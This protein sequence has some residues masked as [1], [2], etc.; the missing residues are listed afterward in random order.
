LCFF[1]PR[2]TLRLAGQEH[3]RGIPLAD[4]RTAAKSTTIRSHH[5]V[6][7]LPSKEEAPARSRGKGQ[8]ELSEGNSDNFS[9]SRTR[10]AAKPLKARW[11]R[12]IPAKQQRTHF[13]F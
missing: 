10:A 5:L 9:L 12:E 11:Q 3:G 4:K 8:L 7:A 1:I 6:G 2:K 13:L